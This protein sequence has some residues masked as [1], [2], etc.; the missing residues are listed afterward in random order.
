MGN[1]DFNTTEKITVKLNDYLTFFRLV[2]CKV[3]KL[4]YKL[5]VYRNIGT[6]KQLFIDYQIKD[7]VR[8]FLAK[9]CRISMFLNN[10]STLI[11]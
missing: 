8:Q 1:N 7:A 4:S 11:L 10:D 9:Y 3:C 5:C 2:D 6:S